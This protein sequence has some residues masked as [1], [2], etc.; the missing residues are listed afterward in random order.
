MK[1]IPSRIDQFAD[2]LIHKY[3]SNIDVSEVYHHTSTAAA[4]KILESAS[5]YISNVQN[6]NDPFEIQYSLSL[7]KDRIAIVDINEDRGVK[8]VVHEFLQTD[9]VDN[10]NSYLSRMYLFSSSLEENAYI[11]E[12]FFSNS[13]CVCIKIDNIKFREKITN[14]EFYLKNNNSKFRAYSSFFGNVLYKNRK[15]QILI[16]QIVQKYSD[17]I[18]E[19]IRESGQSENEDLEAIRAFAFLFLCL[20]KDDK[21]RQENEYRGI[22]IPDT[23]FS[24]VQVRRIGDRTI[25]YIELHLDD[26]NFIE[27]IIILPHQDKSKTTL[28]E[29]CEQK[30]VNYREV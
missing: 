4:V 29:L 1:N 13:N 20:F 18:I 12:S 8:Q 27:E 22:L 11:Y 16:K 17:C 30:G 26:L 19:L 21:F 3:F 14:T 23:V 6:M 15:Q 7:L 9:F 24:N 5:L 28:I 2:K 10:I 25:N